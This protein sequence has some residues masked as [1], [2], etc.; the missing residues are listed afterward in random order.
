MLVENIE[1]RRHLFL[2]H[3]TR[4]FHQGKGL[5]EDLDIPEV[6][7]RGLAYLFLGED[8]PALAGGKI[9]P[10]GLSVEDRLYTCL[11]Q[12]F[13]FFR[14]VNN[15]RP[16]S[17]PRNASAP[18]YSP[19]AGSLRHGIHGDN[20]PHAPQ[21]GPACRVEHRAVPVT[22]TVLMPVSP[23]IR[24]RLVPKNLS[25]PR[26][27]HRFPGQRRERLCDVSPGRLGR[28]AVD[29]GHSHGSGMP[30]E[31]FHAGDRGDTSRSALG[32]CTSGN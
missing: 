24:S 14:H 30:E 32:G 21:G 13:F 22:I 26:G 1:A 11:Y 7:P 4:R 31:P 19:R 12:T 15:I 20:R 3:G 27:Y 16:P 29:D 6:Y 28:E 25:G 8:L 9:L 17:G 23:R 18:L 2:T 10:N 5:S